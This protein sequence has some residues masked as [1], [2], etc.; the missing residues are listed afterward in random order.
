LSCR[1]P[2]G[3]MGASRALWREAA[4]AARQPCRRPR[5]RNGGRA[6]WS[7]W[8]APDV[9]E[10]KLRNEPNH[11]PGI[12]VVPEIEGQRNQGNS[13]AGWARSTPIP[14]RSP[15]A[16]PSF[17]RRCRHGFPW[18]HR[19]TRLSARPLWAL[20]AQNR[21]LA[22]QAERS[23]QATGTPNEPERRRNPGDLRNRKLAIPAVR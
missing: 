17:L 1:T 23:G 14:R 8:G 19:P 7:S 13:S 5:T 10:K 22:L 2:R 11:V 4:I 3:G 20:R 18:S 15:A 12:L 6:C 21:T 16:V 9:D